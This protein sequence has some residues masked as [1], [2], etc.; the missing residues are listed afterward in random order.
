M[1]ESIRGRQPAP[2]ADEA[3]R[4][5]ADPLAKIIVTDLLVITAGFLLMVVA[6]IL[7]VEG[8]SLN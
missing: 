2:N 8:L 1:F 4:P 7:T 6:V 5:L 3:G